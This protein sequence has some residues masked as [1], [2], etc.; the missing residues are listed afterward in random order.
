MKYVLIPVD[1]AE[2]ARVVEV[3]RATSLAVLQNAVGGWIEDVRF[4]DPHPFAGHI[5]FVN[6]EGRAQ[7]LKRNARA[8]DLIRGH[9]F[10]GDFIKGDVVICGPADEDGYE[11]DV[12]EAVLRYFDLS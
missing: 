7:G 10:P 5:M 2:P 6:E 1:T 11:T 12:D 4:R 8:D 9:L 3:T